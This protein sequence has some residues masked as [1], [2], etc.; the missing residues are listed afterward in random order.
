MIS[1]DAVAHDCLHRHASVVLVSG[2]F[3]QGVALMTVARGQH[4]FAIVQL[5][6]FGIC[7]R[8]GAESP[9]DGI[10]RAA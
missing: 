1:T 10:R 2:G 9:M 3:G 6:Y 7:P 4:H 8:L 5:K